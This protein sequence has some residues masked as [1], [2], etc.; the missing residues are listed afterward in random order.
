VLYALGRFDEAEEMTRI[1]EDAAATDDLS[2]QLEWRQVRAKLLGRGGRLDEAV[3]LGEEAIA[4]SQGADFHDIADAY[5]DLAEVYQ[6][7]GRTADA[8]HALREGVVIYERKGNV[9]LV[10]RTE[11]LIAELARS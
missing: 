6:M 10:T 3:R 7:A 4:L 11:A 5:V 1:A 2:S 9:V 8:A